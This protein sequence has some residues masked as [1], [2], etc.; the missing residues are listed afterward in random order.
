MKKFALIGKA[1]SHSKSPQMYKT[2]LNI[3][4]E[5]HLLDFNSE[6]EI[7]SLTKLSQ[8]YLGLNITSP[9]KKLFLKQVEFSETV[10]KCQSLNCLKFIDNIWKAENTDYLAIDELLRSKFQKYLNQPVIVLG[11][12]VMSSVLTAVLTEAKRSFVVLSRKKTKYF[13][14]INLEEYTD[15]K[16]PLL[17]VNTCSRDYVFGGKLPQDALFWDFNYS[18]SPHLNHSVLNSSNYV[19]GEELLFLQAKYACIF[20]SDIINS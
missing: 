4:H 15:D 18:F 19:D 6:L 14:Q 12:G 9:Y 11:D 7:P 20:W 1:I 5:Y 13:D 10:R 8:T 2:L 3:P 17:I 16:N